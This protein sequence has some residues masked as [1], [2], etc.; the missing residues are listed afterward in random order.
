L[1]GQAD[2]VGKR[3]AFR[4]KIFTKFDIGKRTKPG[5]YVK[6]KEPRLL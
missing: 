3:E 4:M 2:A 5:D 6:V 1:C